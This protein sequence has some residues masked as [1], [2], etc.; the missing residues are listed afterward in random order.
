MTIQAARYMPPGALA[1]GLCALG[2]GA[3]NVAVINMSPTL[4][5]ILVLT[6]TPN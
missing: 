6:L 1:D 3:A 2:A 4:A 5:P